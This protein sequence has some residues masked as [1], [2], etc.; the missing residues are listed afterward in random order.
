[1]SFF[2]IE[3]YL[4][5]KVVILH[6]IRSS[7]ILTGEKMFLLLSEKNRTK[8]HSVEKEHWLIVKKLACFILILYPTKCEVGQF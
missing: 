6:F 4:I 2:F 1:M 5:Q 8:E 3:L 7:T